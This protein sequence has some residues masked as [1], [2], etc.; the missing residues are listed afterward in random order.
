MHLDPECYKER[1]IFFVRSGG[2]YLPCC[3][4]STNDAF[5]KL[6]G[7]DL[8]DQLNLNTYSI[9][10]I[11]KSQAWQKIRDLIESDDPPPVCKN[12]C[13]KDRNENADLAGNEQI[14]SIIK[15]KI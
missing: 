7:P 14:M 12:T 5:Y 6:L 4:I 2:T 1:A 11:T 10:E 3:Y 13:R 15:P 9:E 8:Y